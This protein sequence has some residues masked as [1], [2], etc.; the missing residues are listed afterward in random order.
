MTR[1]EKALSYEIQTREELDPKFR[2]RIQLH[3]MIARGRLKDALADIA[4]SPETIDELDYKVR[5]YGKLLSVVLKMNVVEKTKD[6]AFAE[7]NVTAQNEEAE[8]QCE[9]SS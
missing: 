1:E 6:D 2:D 9:S 5:T 3:L 4:V 7:A 8:K